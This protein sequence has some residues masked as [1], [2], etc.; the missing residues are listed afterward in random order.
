MDDK[1]PADNNES[2]S[3]WL[4]SLAEAAGYRFEGARSG[5]LTRLAEDTG[6]SISVV[7][8]AL[9]GERTPD[10]Q[11]LR[12]LSRPLG[13]NLREMLIKSGQADETDLPGPYIPRFE[14]SDLERRVLQS[15]VARL[16][17]QLEVARERF[18]R[19][20]ERRER[21]QA[22]AAAAEESYYNCRAEVEQL[23]QTARG[24]RSVLGSP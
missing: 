9:S 13:T 22:D 5:G 3:G 21:A 14:Q 7:S 24:L 2:F 18:Q 11:T 8:R 1:L 4:R 16:E 15:E 12:A 6:L 23:E 10:V 17:A 20:A 19:A